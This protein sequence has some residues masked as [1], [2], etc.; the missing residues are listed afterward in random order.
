MA[1]VVRIEHVAVVEV[2]APACF[3]CPFNMGIRMLTG[4]LNRYDRQADGG[5]Q[6]GCLLP[7]ATI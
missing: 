2:T 3:K 7:K 1:A 5:K 4:S 6:R